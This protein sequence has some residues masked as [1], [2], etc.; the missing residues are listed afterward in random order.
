MT[1]E[2]PCDVSMVLETESGKTV[3]LK[4]K[5]SLEAGE[6]IDVG[7]GVVRVRAGLLGSSRLLVG[8]Q[9]EELKLSVDLVDL[10]RIRVSNK[11]LGEPQN[12]VS[13]CRRN[14]FQ[15]FSG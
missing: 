10:L 13:R 4:E 1:M 5:V 2:A 7:A 8:K 6:I 15:H 11:G 14:G 3:V 9:R 12:R